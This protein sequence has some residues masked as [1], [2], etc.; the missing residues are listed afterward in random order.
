MA[1]NPDAVLLS[2]YAFS[3]SKNN[4]YYSA[5]GE[6]DED[7]SCDAAATTVQC[8]TGYT[9]DG[10]YCVLAGPTLNFED[11]ESYCSEKDDNLVFAELYSEEDLTNIKEHIQKDTRK[12]LPTFYGAYN[13]KVLITYPQWS[14]YNSGLGG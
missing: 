9:F 8:D 10:R 4:S 2:D 1:R 6:E 13:F 3:D 12:F 11:A 7:Q 5:A 14:V